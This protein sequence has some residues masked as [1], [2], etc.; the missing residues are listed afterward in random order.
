MPKYII[1][2]EDGSKYEV[3]TE[4]QKS[5]EKTL[6]A[7]QENVENVEDVGVLGNIFLEPSVA[8]SREFARQSTGLSKIA[9]LLPAGIGS[10]LASM[11]AFGKKNQEIVNK[12]IASPSTSQT[13]QDEAIDDKHV[14]LAKQAG[15]RTGL[16][17]PDKFLGK[18]LLYSELVFSGGLSSTIG[19]AKD[20]YTNPIDVLFGITD[21]AA[22]G[23]AAKLGG[24]VAVNQA[25]NI[26][27]KYAKAVKLGTGKI[28]KAADI[29]QR[30]KKII[31]GLEAATDQARSAGRLPQNTQEALDL[32]HDTKRAIY[33]EYT[34][35]RKTA[36]KGDATIDFRKVAQD[37]AESQS[38]QG[39]RIS[40]PK[41]REKA[42]QRAF[43]LA[44]EGEVSLDVADDAVR[45]L[46]AQR[47]KNLSSN[48]DDVSNAELNETV[49]QAIRRQLDTVI[50]AETGQEYSA[51]KQTYGSL[52]EIEGD[53]AKQV[54][55]LGKQS[56]NGLVRQLSESIDNVPLIY[57][58][59]SGNV[60]LAGASI[61]QKII[62]GV[63]K[64]MGSTDTQI[65]N[66]FAG[67]NKIKDG[68]KVAPAL[69]TIST[70][71]R[72]IPQGDNK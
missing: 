14:M 43:E 47:P 33:D 44:Q 37:V 61:F 8:G 4:D 22:V 2:V 16:L 18:A 26:G 55:R 28:K 6:S 20:M 31:V 67:I 3:T 46:N 63:T 25:K 23:K 39:S 45:N 54:V 5:P 72:I 12:A 19:L 7:P 40:N 38:S 9:S 36:Q 69:S 27:N 13:F 57:G 42:M 66:L 34:A 41:L 30:N 51:L 71:R 10:N 29:T 48:I 1:T 65:K 58:I 21:I 35:L 70:G 56:G 60:P 68:R 64:S 52:S 62:K 24:K 32:V 50:Q 11:G 53:L 49:A 15:E 17:A 59:L